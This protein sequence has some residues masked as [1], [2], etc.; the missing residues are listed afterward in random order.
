MLEK[1]K[2]YR[3]DLHQIPELGFELTK[4]Y[5]YVKSMLISFGYEPKTYAKTGLVAVKKGRLET[6][7]AFRA[8]MDALPV[9]ENLDGDNFKV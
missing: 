8:D 7:I 1:L 4:T 5:Q 9:T 6:S 2:G 3:R